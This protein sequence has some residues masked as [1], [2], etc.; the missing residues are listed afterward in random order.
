MWMMP[1]RLTI[2]ATMRNHKN[3]DVD[4]NLKLCDTI[5]NYGV[6]SLVDAPF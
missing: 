2:V 4:C 1:L 3:L 5:T 6:I